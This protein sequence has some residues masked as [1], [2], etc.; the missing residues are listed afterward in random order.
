MVARKLDIQFD[1]F[2]KA[3]NEI[4]GHNSWTNNESDP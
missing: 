3:A 4:V 1:R 2:G